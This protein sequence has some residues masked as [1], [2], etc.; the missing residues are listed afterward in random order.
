MNPIWNYSIL[1]ESCTYKYQECM[2]KFSH[3]AR[4]YLIGDSSF[5]KE[6]QILLSV[7]IICKVH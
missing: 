3:M 2:I 4:P 7:F 6:K 1:S 5:L